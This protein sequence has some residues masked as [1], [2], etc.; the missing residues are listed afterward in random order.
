MTPD[1]IHALANECAT[2][3]NLPVDGRDSLA[4]EGAIVHALAA[5]DCE[6]PTEQELM[7]RLVRAERDSASWLQ[8][9][10]Q[11]GDQL[12]A[13]SAAASFDPAIH[14]DLETCVRAL[15]AE[16]DDL[17]R[18]KREMLTVVHWW[19]QIDDFVRAH[20]DILVGDSVSAKALEWLKERDE[21]LALLAACTDDLEKVTHDNVSLRFAASGLLAK[22]K[23]DGGA[24]EP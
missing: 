15:Y 20:K 22:V 8:Q 19:Q 17:A 9:F 12:R 1:Q 14:R 13:V 3:L 2:C 10:M 6:R 4:I 7:E 21:A 23:A 5:D 18:W 24:V 11:R 16:R